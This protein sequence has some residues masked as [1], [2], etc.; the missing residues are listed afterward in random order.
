LILA[1]GIDDADSR[2]WLLARARLR[3]ASVCPHCWAL[4][5]RREPVPLPVVQVDPG[6]VHGGGYLVA[7]SDRGL[8]SQLRVEGASGVLYRGAEP[9]RWL[10]DRGTQLLLAGPPVAVA[11]GLAVLLSLFNFPSL[12]PVVGLLFVAAFTY[13][14]VHVRW[15]PLGD[16]ADRA[17]DAAWTLLVP[18]LRRQ[19][20]SPEVASFLGGLALASI[21]RGRPAVRRLILARWIQD[22]EAAVTNG[23]LL[24]SQLAPLWRLAIED[25]AI[26]GRDPVVLTVNQVERVLRGGLPLSFAD[27]LLTDWHS[28]IWE[29]G[30]LARLRVL[31]CERAFEAELEVPDLVEVGRLAP[32]LGE[33]LQIEDV[34]GLTRLRLLWTLRL[35]RPWQPPGEAATVFELA[36]HAQRGATLLHEW[37][38]LL[39]AETSTSETGE[40][41]RTCGRGVIFQGRLIREPPTSLEVSETQRRWG[42]RYRLRVGRHRFWFRDPPDTV[43]QRLERWLNYHFREFLP[44][45]A[46][47]REWRSLGT[48]SRLQLHE[49]GCCPECGTP[50]REAP[51]EVGKPLAQRTR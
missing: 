35:G 33:A 23:A 6:R 37:P 31:L 48:L 36:A 21:G 43:V 12:L 13:A 29:G 28:T 40:G 9:E 26:A 44:Q 42:R 16:S 46:A 24:G 47:V 18:K 32:A 3:Q 51:G 41:V 2:R 30:Q 19:G 38:D 27:A 5:P 34:D 50:F 8:F 15:Q 10:T 20:L 7:V 25:A 49:I 11:L 22:V 4:V 45:A 17:V 39:L 14:V 1:R